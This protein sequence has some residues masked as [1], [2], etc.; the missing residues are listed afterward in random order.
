MGYLPLKKQTRKVIRGHVQRCNQPLGDGI[1]SLNVPVDI[2]LYLLF[3][4][5]EIPWAIF[6]DGLPEWAWNGEW[7]NVS[8]FKNSGLSHNSIQGYLKKIFRYTEG[9]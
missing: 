2:R 1:T 5:G 7:F 9:M 6:M 8:E 4:E 3:M